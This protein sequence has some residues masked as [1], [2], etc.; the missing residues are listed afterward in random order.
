M[1]I[2]SFSIKPGTGKIWL[3]HVQCES[4]VTRLSDCNLR[5]QKDDSPWKCDHTEDLGVICNSSLT[6]TAK[7]STIRTTTVKI[8]FFPPT[9]TK[10]PEASSF[11]PIILSLIVVL[12]IFICAFGMGI[13]FF[14]W[15]YRKE[16]RI[17]QRQEERRQRRIDVLPP[18][19]QIAQIPNGSPPMFVMQTN[20]P[21]NQPIHLDTL[22]QPPPYSHDSVKPPDYNQVAESKSP[23]P[24]TPTMTN[25]M[26]NVY[27]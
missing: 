2:F 7:Q 11:S 15:N 5:F 21:V 22:N 25:Q 12:S 24:Y 23:P 18:T 19:Q 6:S 20:Y 10:V 17:R 8:T 16:Q 26:P 14:F 27:N 4:N 13:S 3:E 1:K 9:S